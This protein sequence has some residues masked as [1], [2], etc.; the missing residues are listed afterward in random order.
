VGNSQQA[1]R[2]TVRENELSRNLSSRS[3]LPSAHQSELQRTPGRPPPRV[4]GPWQPGQGRSSRSRLFLRT[5]R[6][7]RTRFRL[8]RALRLP[9]TSRIPIRLIKQEAR[10]QAFQ[11]TEVPAWPS[12]LVRIRFQ[13]RLHSPRRV[14][15]AFPH[16]NWSLSSPESF[17]PWR[18]G[19]PVSPPD[20]TCPV[21][22]GY[23]LRFRSIFVTWLL[24]FLA[25]LSTGSPN[26]RGGGFF[27][28]G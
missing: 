14:L 15:F 26:V 20:Y 13:S 27:L 12:L 2:K 22:S 1:A 3:P 8:R 11:G 10:R 18:V 6:P 23:A 28:V 4:S 5:C 16:R 7:I 24:T 21:V 17:S 19:S 25:P 9:C